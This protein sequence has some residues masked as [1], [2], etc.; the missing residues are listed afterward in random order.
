[1]SVVRFKRYLIKKYFHYFTSN[2][3]HDRRIFFALVKRSSFL[4]TTSYVKAISVL[5]H[6]VNLPFCQTAFKVMD[7][8]CVKVRLSLGKGLIT[9]G[10]CYKK[11]QI[12]Y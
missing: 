3:E 9:W 2:V 7:G 10:L 4:L 8:K 5:S 6:F 12:P 1:M 11:L